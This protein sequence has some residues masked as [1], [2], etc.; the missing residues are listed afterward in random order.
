VFGRALSFALVLA[1]AVAIVVR[2]SEGAG[3]E[4]IYVVRHADTLWSIASAHYRGDPR[5]G[6]WE[7][8]ERNHLRS[9]LLRP[10][11]RLVLP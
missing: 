8:R 10:G 7:L 6:V 2:P 5:E 4:Q 1:I 9:T 3:R 11:Q